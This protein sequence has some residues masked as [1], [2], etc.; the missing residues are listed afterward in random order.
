M[1]RILRKARKL[2]EHV[3]LSFF[4]GASVI[5]NDNTFTSET[6]LKRHELMI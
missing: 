4:S 3:Y 6:G 1:F 5:T 2:H